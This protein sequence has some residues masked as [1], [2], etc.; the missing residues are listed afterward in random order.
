MN[1]KYLPSK[2]LALSWKWEPSPFSRNG[3]IQKTLRQHDTGLIS[4]YEAYC[5]IRQHSPEV[6]EAEVI[7]LII[8][9]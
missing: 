9:V 3:M 5:L 7:F 8:G 2:K 4:A 6:D 1:S